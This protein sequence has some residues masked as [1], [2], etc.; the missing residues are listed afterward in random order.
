M[1]ALL[2]CAL[3]FFSAC[4][5]PRA[6][7]SS[8]PADLRPYFLVLLVN[9][10][11]ERIPMPENVFA[12]HMA[13]MNSHFASGVYK[14]GGPLT[15]GG[16]IRGMMLMEAENLAAARTIVEHD[17]AVLAGVLAPEVHP[18]LARSLAA[19]D[20]ARAAEPPVAQPSTAPPTD[21]R[22]YFLVML[23]N[24]QAEPIPMPDDVFARHMAFRN[25][26]VASGAYKAGGPVTD[27]GHIRGV[28]IVEGENLEAVLAIANNDPAV[29]A[30]ILTVEAHPM[31]SRDLSVLTRASH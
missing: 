27:G 24:P 29:R 10:G 19:F 31:F 13:Y 8:P 15:D 25:A 30:G 5:T 23:V 12:E 21:L 7:D 6:P 11:P 18:M 9:P 20:A 26:R 1:R 22:P 14:I 4:A 3:L 16:R 28:S 17:P 2:F